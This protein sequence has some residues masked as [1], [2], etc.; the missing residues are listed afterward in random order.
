MEST[1]EPSEVQ[2]LFAKHA[3]LSVSS[4]VHT[5]LVREV[6]HYTSEIKID[7]ESDILRQLY[8]GVQ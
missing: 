6:S 7:A 3:K 8:I 1:V 5:L 2:C 4:V